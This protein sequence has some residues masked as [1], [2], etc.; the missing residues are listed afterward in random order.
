M[1]ASLR[2][3]VVLASFSSLAALGGCSGS[4]SD[5]N[6]P[7][8]RTPSPT[9]TATGGTT[10]P[11]PSETKT[12]GP[13]AETPEA[14]ATADEDPN[15]PL[16][17]KNVSFTSASSIGGGW[18]GVDV[19]FTVEKKTNLTIDRVQEVSV[20]FDGEKRTFPV[21]CSGSWF[22]MYAS[23]VI[24]LSVDDSGTSSQVGLG[25]GSS[26]VQPGTTKPWGENV[27]IELRGLLDDATP[28]RAKG[29]GSR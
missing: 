19:T 6:D 27:T 12:P 2:C 22:E 26:S 18:Q 5:V 7:F 16:R 24:T 20:T 4:T 1:T 10:P 28:W 29:T 3:L 15:A 21:T 25:C 17:I 11:P 14:P 23:K 13:T 9:T 8:G